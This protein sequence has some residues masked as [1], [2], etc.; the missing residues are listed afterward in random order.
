MLGKG[1]FGSVYHALDLDTGRVYAAKQVSLENGAPRAMD[2]I[3]NEVLALSRLKHDHI[4]I[5]FGSEQTT[6]EFTVFMEYCPGGDISSILRQYGPLALKVT[7]IYT[8]QLLQGLAYLHTENVVHRDIKG[9]NVLLMTDGTV[10]LADFGMSLLT[11]AELTGTMSLVGSP[12]WMPPEVI[13]GKKSSKT[14]DVWSMGATVWE[15]LTGKP[16][17]FEKEP[18]AAIFAIGSM[19]ELPP[20]PAVLDDCPAGRAFILD[21]MSIKVSAHF[22]SLSDVCPYCGLPFSYRWLLVLPCNHCRLIRFLYNGLR[23]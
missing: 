9:A 20:L 3:K 8:R 17:L 11:P 7:R 23:E 15:M 22:L 19:K 4:V 6:K 10:K 14:S 16:F 13:Q 1:G 2:S 12:Y 18:T 5:Y 21:A